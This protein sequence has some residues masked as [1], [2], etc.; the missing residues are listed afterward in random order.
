MCNWCEVITRRYAAAGRVLAWN[1]QIFSSSE[2]HEPQVAEPCAR[3]GRRV[4]TPAGRV[5]S[6]RG[7]YHTDPAP[8]EVRSAPPRARTHRRARIR[9]MITLWQQGGKRRAEMDKR[10]RDLR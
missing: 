8:G 10:A 7:R 1:E 9:A 3:P 2:R 5:G 6:C 4:I